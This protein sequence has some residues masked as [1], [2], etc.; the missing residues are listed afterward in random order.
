VAYILQLLSHYILS[1]MRI[2]SQFPRA[3]VEL[4]LAHWQIG[5]WVMLVGILIAWMSYK[6]WRLTQMKHF[7]KIAKFTAQS[8]N[9][10]KI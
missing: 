2:L 9:S 6:N 7:Q 3:L 4:K 5:L 10:S 1:V 8:A